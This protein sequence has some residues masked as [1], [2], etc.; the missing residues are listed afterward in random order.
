[1]KL[2]LVVAGNGM[3]G[4]RVVET[5]SRLVPDQFHITVIGREPR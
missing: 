4:M 5:L 2:H 3:A 1:M